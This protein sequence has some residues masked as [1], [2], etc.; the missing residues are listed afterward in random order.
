MRWGPVGVVKD[1]PLEIKYKDVIKKN[2]KFTL[3]D[4][5]K[6]KK[7]LQLMFAVHRF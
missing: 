7:W 3:D 1:Q 5:E 6:Q 2:L 4:L